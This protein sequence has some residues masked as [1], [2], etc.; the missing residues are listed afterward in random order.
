[1][2]PMPIDSVPFEERPAGALARS[3]GEARVALDGLI[4]SQQRLTAE[5]TLSGRE[6]TQFGHALSRAFVGLIVQGRSFGDVL[7]SLVASLSRLAL[8]IAFRPLENLLGRA[9]QG[10]VGSAVGG[11]GSPVDRAMSKAPAVTRHDALR[12]GRGT[13]SPVTAAGGLAA[14][15]ALPVAAIGMLPARRSDGHPAGPDHSRAGAAPGWAAL[16]TPVVLNVTTP[17]ADSFRRSETQIAALLARAV[18]QGQRNL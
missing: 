10:L 18:G 4:E 7:R 8:G 2:I 3:A 12:L 6:G 16:Q 1:M 15:R 13:P 5:L 9:L 17:D 14:P 11:T